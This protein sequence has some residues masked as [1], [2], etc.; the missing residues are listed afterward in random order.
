ME[1]ANGQNIYDSE[2]KIEPRGSF[3]PALGLLHVYH[4]M[5]TIIIKHVYW[6]MSQISG[7]RLHDHLSSG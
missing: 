3:V 7:E 6:Y 1:W 2:N 4:N 5:S